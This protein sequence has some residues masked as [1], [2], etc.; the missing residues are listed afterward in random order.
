MVQKD[1][2]CFDRRCCFSPCFRA[3]EN[4]YYICCYL[5]VFSRYCVF[6]L[7]Y[8]KILRS[9]YWQYPLVIRE[10]VQMPL[11]NNLSFFYSSLSRV[12]YWIEAIKI[13]WIARCGRYRNFKMFE[14]Y[15]SF[16][17]APVCKNWSRLR[18]NANSTQNVSKWEDIGHIT[19]VSISCNH[20]SYHTT[21]LFQKDIDVLGKMCVAKLSEY[22]LERLEQDWNILW[23]INIF[24]CSVFEN[25]AW[26]LL[27]F[28]MTTAQCNAEFSKHLEI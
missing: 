3:I 15:G 5:I 24:L 7:E 25:K 19:M 23:Q 9:V 6:F 1:L 21:K 14:R 8:N 16:I 2:K 28:D 4:Y 18:L 20:M 22:E 13:S 11:N 10:N 12:F 27:V 17:V 26:L